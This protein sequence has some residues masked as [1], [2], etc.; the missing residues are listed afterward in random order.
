MASLWSEGVMLELEH[1]LEDSPVTEHSLIAPDQNAVFLPQSLRSS[2]HRNSCYNTDS[3]YH[4]ILYPEGAVPL[5]TI[6]TEK[7][8][9]YAV[10]VLY[11]R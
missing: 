10:F 6:K 5:V 3:L 4:V 7:L 9:K 8:L 2:F 1:G 11:H